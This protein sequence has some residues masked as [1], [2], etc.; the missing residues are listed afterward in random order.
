MPMKRLMFL[1]LAVLISTF[2]YSQSPAPYCGVLYS[3]V[4][5]NQNGPSNSPFNSVND[6]IN[7]FNT[8]GAVSNITN[9]NSGCCGNSN[10]YIRY[11]CNQHYLQV[12]PGQVITCNIQS[13]T[14]FAQGFAVFIDWNQDNVFNLPA[15]RV[16]ATLGIPP[17][18]TWS[19]ITFTVPLGQP[20]GQYRMR[21]RCAFSTAG[22]NIGPCQNYSYGEAEDYECFVG[23]SPTP[24]A[25]LITTN[26][27]TICIGQSVS[28]NLSGQNGTIQWQS[29]SN[30]NGPWSNIA[31][32]NTQTFTTQPINSNT[33]FRAALTS[34]STTVYT[35]PICI[36]VNQPPIL[37]ITNPTICAGFSSP[38]SV[39]ANPSG[40]NYLWSNGQ[41]TSSILVSPTTT[42]TYTVSYNL[43]GCVSTAT[44]TVT[45]NQNPV[46]SIIGDSSLCLGETTTLSISPIMNCVWSTNQ[47]TP[48]IV[49]TP[50]VSTVYTATITQTNGCSSIIT[51]TVL[52]HPI[53][54]TSFISP[55]TT[56]LGSP[57][58][59]QST[60][61][62][63]QGSIS[64][65]LWTYNSTPIG[66]TSAINYTF[67]S[68][69]TFLVNLTTTSNQ[70]CSS[71]ISN[72]IVVYP[73]PI[74]SFSTPVTSGCSPFCVNLTD[75]TT[76]SGSQI[77]DWVWYANGQQISTFPSPI[78]CFQSPGIYDIQLQ[79]IS[80]QGCSSVLNVPNYIT[81]HPAPI[82]NFILPTDSVSFQDATLLLSNTSVNSN[83]YLWN[84]GDGETSTEMNPIH[85][86]DTVGRLCIELKSFG[87]GGCVDSDT[88][89][90]R[91]Y[92]EFY[93]YIPNTFTPNNDNSNEIFKVSGIGV[94]SVQ[95]NIFDR[96]GKQIFRSP[97]GPLDK[98]WWDG[99]YRGELCPQGV[100]IYSITII[101]E[102]NRAH[103]FCER[104][105]LIR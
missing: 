80:L 76:V 30:Q 59:L 84:F 70:G 49:V 25:G 85:T 14:T 45:V 53:P 72:S 19:A 26:S 2:I 90:I 27:N 104:V 47:T 93:V 96:W 18:N 83:S 39:T 10:N 7:S 103:N 60:S 62:I 9:N 48:S 20:I 50:N 38:I 65:Y 23:M 58:N 1:F 44:S 41:T 12:L 86:W 52:V 56:C 98:I 8:T 77:I 21:V 57:S 75:A 32:A 35:Q 102:K 97:V 64:N 37:Q 4:P 3:N 5:C 73:N 51:D 92:N 40:G 11:N 54:S 17:A 66:N 28:L 71:S 55:F 29:S 22:I 36:S 69:G 31:G 61:I 15:E 16:A 81:V 78:H 89:C 74:V 101:D 42:T 24:I 95:I 33:C 68:S 46:G 34:C 6:F 63:S 13:G 105:N 91:I 100:Y 99:F 79:V 43:N 82:A 88:Q 94:K 67:P 87:I